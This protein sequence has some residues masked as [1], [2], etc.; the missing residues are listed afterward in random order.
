MLRQLRSPR[1][2]T[3]LWI[4]LS[5]IVIPSF[6]VFYGWQSKAPGSGDFTPQA[7]ASIELPGASKIEILQPQ[8]M[9]A[10]DD[11][12]Q[13]VIRYAAVTDRPIDRVAAD[14]MLDTQFVV[15]RAIDLEILKDFARRNGIVVPVDEVIRQYQRQVPPE[16]R[17]MLIAELQRR[18]I[19]FE[20]KVLEDQY[21]L[22]LE[23]VRSLLI[24]QT[25]V[26]LYE[27]WIH[28]RL[29]NEKL[30]LDVARFDVGDY[31]PKVE[32]DEAALTRFFEENRA[33]FRVPDQVEYNYILVRKSDLRTSVTVTDDMI[34]SYFE[35]HKEDFR[36]PRLARVRQI[37]LLKPQPAEPGASE[38]DLTTRI[39]QVRQK[40][41]DLRQ[42][43]AKG[44]SFATLADQAN[45]ETIFPPREDEGTTDADAQTTAGG[46]LGLISETNATAFYGDEWTSSVFGLSPGSISQ[47]IETRRGFHIVQLEE[48]RPGLI[49]DLDKVRTLVRERVV[50]E[51]VGPLFEDMGQQIRENAA[52]YTSLDKLAEV[53]SLTVQK[54]GRVDRTAQFIPN[55]GLLGD[56]R[57]PIRELAKGGRSEVLSDSSR[58]LVIEVAE[59]YP[60]HDPELKDIRAK[61]EAAWREERAREMARSAAETVKAAAKDPAGMQAAA[62]SA[63]TTVTTTQPFKR[64]E[65]ATVVG[66]V[67]DFETE[68]EAARVGDVVLSTLGTASEP[69]GYIVWRVVSKE[70]PAQAEFAKAI[71]KT[72]Q[73]L[74]ERRAMTTL[75]EYMRDRRA[76]FAKNIK[77]NPAYR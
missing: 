76:E 75:H 56:F 16:Q 46:Y 12:R 26:S 20:Q 39:E 47:P 49:P 48:L 34:T 59:E 65:V 32:M 67:V 60:A 74:R 50:D 52:R 18:G 72:V 29:Q 22:L 9:R 7:A 77:I 30:V 21:N 54:T 42:R 2:K 4:G 61:V 11:L 3:A 58:H 25:R 64:S 43:I 71:H 5:I 27:A 73:Q 37:T 6:V 19:S 45:E 36:S 38:D 70:E 53:T 14:N 28:Y 57:E 15:Q 41:S 51:K 13:E 40:A 17:P 68:S 10:K 8:F 66:P 62:V 35:T 69:T 33:R 63:G 55:I 31:L 24:E 44:E 1:L 23:R